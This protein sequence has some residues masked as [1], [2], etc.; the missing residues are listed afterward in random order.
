MRLKRQAEVLP[1]CVTGERRR[2]ERHRS[3]RLAEGRRLLGL[4]AGADDLKPFQVSEGE[5][6]PLPLPCWNFKPQTAAPCNST[7]RCSQRMRPKAESQIQT[8]GRAHGDALMSKPS[9]IS[10]T[11]ITPT[12]W[13]KNSF[14]PSYFC[15]L[16]LNELTDN[17]RVREMFPIEKWSGWILI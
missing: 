16:S 15:R 7:A 9:A 3:D 10:L 6:W 14:L 8:L 13:D 5:D 2:S 12:H 4:R 17:S 11:P 1:A